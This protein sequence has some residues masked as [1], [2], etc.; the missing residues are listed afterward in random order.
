[1]N[2]DAEAHEA[3]SWERAIAAADIVSY[4]RYRLH[5]LPEPM[6]ADLRSRIHAYDAADAAIDR[7][8][9]LPEVAP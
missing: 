1:M 7:A 5:R 9:G 4:L 2:F 6:E 8:L 3:A